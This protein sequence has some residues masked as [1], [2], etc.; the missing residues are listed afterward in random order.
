MNEF[1]EMMAVLIFVTLL[2]G[3]TGLLTVDKIKNFFKKPSQTESPASQQMTAQDLQVIVLH[4]IQQRKEFGVLRQGF[5]SSFTYRNDRKIFGRTLP[6][7]STEIKINYRGNVVC[8]CDLSRAVFADDT[9]N[10]RIKIVIPYGEIFDIYAI[11]G[12]LET[13][14]RKAGIFSRKVDLT[15]YDKELRIDIEKMART[16]ISDGILQK[17]NELVCNALQNLISDVNCEISTEIIFVGDPQRLTAPSDRPQ[18][19]R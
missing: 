2:G 12:T 16:L 13:V 7:T 9:R 10:N 11:S 4:Q 17:T 15:V 19:G 5:E 18:L 1:W 3:V 6:L 14:E 8:G